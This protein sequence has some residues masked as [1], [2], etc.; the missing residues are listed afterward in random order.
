META[1]LLR[2]HAVG[3]PRPMPIAS[4][5]VR[6]TGLLS[7]CLTDEPH[8]IRRL[9]NDLGVTLTT[10]PELREAV[11]NKCAAPLLFTS[12]L[13]PLLK[14]LRLFLSL[15]LAQSYYQV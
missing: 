8:T 4:R 2:D 6:N 14:W 5:T 10:A 15:K 13:V 7:G 1:D 12:G 9:S 3:S 11:S